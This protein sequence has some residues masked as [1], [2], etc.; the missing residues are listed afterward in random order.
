MPSFLKE[1]KRPIIFIGLV[2]FHL[3]LISLQVPLGNEQSLFEKAV[4]GVFS[5]LQHAMSSVF[6]GIGNFWSRYV[7][8]RSVEA[9]NQQMRKELFF[10]RQETNFLKNSL[11]RFKTEREIQILLANLKGSFLL[12][13]V[14]G[15]DA[16][17]PYKS[18][19]INRGSLDG[20]KKDMA[21]IDKF[22]NLVGRVIDPISFQE[23]RVQLITDADSGVSVYCGPDRSVG[24]LAGNGQGKCRVKYV[25]ASAKDPAIGEEI[26]TTG[27][28]RIFPAGIK[29]G[30]VLSS[31]QDTSLF[32][33]ISV[34]PLFSYG[35]LSEVAALT[36]P[37]GHFF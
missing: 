20:L 9:E 19:V 31:L 36:A 24:V 23:G 34:E 1:K 18:V 15:I 6:G 12:A 32:K 16:S 13:Q 5:P 17:N 4:F 33:T 30:R 3:V 7:H 26:T 14:I 25:L 2:F 28:D 21:V 8:L 27:F 35:G 37:A 11:L 22:G 10:L 29:V